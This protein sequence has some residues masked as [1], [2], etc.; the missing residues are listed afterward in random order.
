MLGSALFNLLTIVA[1]SILIKKKEK[2]FLLGVIIIMYSLGLG[3]YSYPFY[4]EV[5]P[6][7]HEV[8]SYV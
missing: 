1:V 3:V 7:Y 4:K 8:H 5:S 6:S 2:P